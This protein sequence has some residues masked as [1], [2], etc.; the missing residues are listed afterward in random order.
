MRAF[1]TFSL[2]VAILA[3]A[4][5]SGPG[6]APAGNVGPAAKDAGDL[7][8]MRSIDG[9]PGWTRTGP[10]VRYSKEGL[11]G[12]I[13]GGA[14]IVL[15]YGFR[16]LAVSEFAPA[17]AAAGPA[18]G[19]RVILEIYR[20]TTGQ[21]AYGLYST[22]L[23]G[24]EKGWPGVEADNWVGFGQAN[25]VKGEFLVNVLAPDCADEEIGRFLAAVE[26]KVPG[27]GTVR[28]EGLAWLPREGKV[29]SSWRYIKGPLAAANE[30][31]FL[32]GDYWGFAAGPE[33]EGAAEAFSAKY[34]TAP[35]VSK[36]VVVDLGRAPA[37]DEI[38]DGVVATFEEY[39]REV[40]REGETIEARSEDGRSFLY[41]R[42]RSVAA[43][44]L[45]EPDRDAALSRLETALA[46]AASRSNAR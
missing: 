16:E 25:L 12:H 6:A 43:L 22:K 38:E 27:S 46:L 3:A 37:S 5:C 30:S 40:R 15:Q 31:P 9:I 18:S 2:A 20:M 26:P 11:Y 13:D 36:L 23:E 42:A 35:A 14:E 45:G 17:G 28:P 7:P 41:R 39:L 33:G 24:G 32:E 1:R 8:V 21:A 34:G 29:P 10:A 19:K 44:V 4:A